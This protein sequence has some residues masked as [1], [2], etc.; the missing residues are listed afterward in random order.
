MKKLLLSVVFSAFLFGFFNP[1]PTA[2]K[3]IENGGPLSS[4]DAYQDG[5]GAMVVEKG[6]GVDNS[7]MN[8][9]VFKYGNVAKSNSLTVGEQVILSGTAEDKLLAGK[10]FADGVNCND[11]NDLSTGETWLN[12]VCQG[13]NIPNGTTCDDINVMT[14]NDI[15]TNNICSGTLTVNGQVCDDLNS[16]T[17]TDTYTNGVCAGIPSTLNVVD[18]FGDGS[19]KGLYQFENNV[20]GNSVSGTVSYIAGKFGQAS[21]FNGSTYV[22]TGSTFSLGTVG[23]FSYWLYHNGQASTSYEISNYTS[24]SCDGTNLISTQNQI[25]INSY[26]NCSIVPVSQVGYTIPSPNSWYHVVGTIAADSTVTLYVNGNLIGS[27][28]GGTSVSK[29]NTRSYYIGAYYGGGYTTKAIDQLRV[30]NKILNQTEVTKLFN[31]K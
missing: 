19:G 20:N 11:N 23:S 15:F 18:I 12:G 17:H 24:A 26:Q 16:N 10:L 28:K 9:L 31:E 27:N 4:I 30:F 5:V 2:S 8:A 29:L 3:S 22:N 7:A 13:G 1:L 14:I 21:K 25:Y 6:R